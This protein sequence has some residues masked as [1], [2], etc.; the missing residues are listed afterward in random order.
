MASREE[1]QRKIRMVLLGKTG[2]GKSSTGNTILNG[3]KKFTT[4]L[5]GSSVTK[6]CQSH[7]VN[8]FGRDVLVVDTP[9]VFDTDTPND[10]IME[11]LKK[12]ILLSAPG[13]HVFILV[14]N[15]RSRF[16]PEEKK[17]VETF[18]RCFGKEMY[19]YSIVLFTGKDDLIKVEKNEEKYLN[20]NEDELQ[21][22]LNRCENRCIF[23]NNFASEEEKNQQVRCLLDMIDKNV[24][25]NNG[26]YYKVPGT[27]RTMLN[28]ATT[29]GAV[30][31]TS[32]FFFKKSNN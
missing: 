15:G 5:G 14:F 25:A 3:D 4:G 18:V 23:F 19:K 29:I 2:S 24:A 22:I 30:L 11:E 21:E 20:E 7:T 6:K 10:S 8:R 9:G 31:L 13:P 28:Y 26:S 16:T 1:D 27:I 32:I 12:C 17:A